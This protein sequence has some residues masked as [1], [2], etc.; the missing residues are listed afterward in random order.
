M[1]GRQC[2]GNDIKM[3]R[4][5]CERHPHRDGHEGTVS[6]RL[7]SRTAGWKQRSATAGRSCCRGPR[8]PHRTDTARFLL[9]ALPALLDAVV[10]GLAVLPHEFRRNFHQVCKSPWS[11]SGLHRESPCPSWIR[12][13]SQQ[14]TGACAECTGPGSGRHLPGVL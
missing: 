1:R 11:Q 9:V 12:T 6:H 3:A 5:R 14:N 7:F 4:G 10:Q 8:S 13:V 2:L